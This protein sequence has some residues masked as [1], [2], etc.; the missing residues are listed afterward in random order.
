MWNKECQKYGVLSNRQLIKFYLWC[1]DF[2]PYNEDFPFFFF[3]FFNPGQ[4]VP[5]EVTERAAWLVY[6]FCFPK[7]NGRVRT[8]GCNNPGPQLPI[9]T[10][11]LVPWTSLVSC[12]WLLLILVSIT[13]STSL[14]L[15]FQS[16][17]LT[18]PSFSPVLQGLLCTHMVPA[19]NMLH[20]GMVRGWLGKLPSPVV[21]T[22][23][24]CPARV[25]APWEPGLGIFLSFFPVLAPGTEVSTQQKLHK[26]LPLWLKS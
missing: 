24:I 20:S 11:L 9:W 23:L 8:A 14:L 5:D 16:H 10:L 1:E 22:G 2:Q 25:G 13:G 12:L 3:F 6:P 19:P 4:F 21:L 18:P 15:S 17:F 26:A 7:F